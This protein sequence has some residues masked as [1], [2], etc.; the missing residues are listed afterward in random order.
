MF[1]LRKSVLS[2][3]VQ[4]HQGTDYA[5]GIRGLA[6]LAVLAV[7]GGA[8]YPLVE[9][10]ERIGFGREISFNLINLGTAGPAAFFITSGF[11]LSLVWERQRRFGIQKWIIRRY[12]R[13]TPL[14]A[15]VLIYCMLSGLNLSLNDAL[16]RLFYLDAF[17]EKI[18]LRD[19]IGVLWTISIE[20]WLSLFVPFFVHLFRSGK[21]SELVL[22]SAFICSS[23][24]PTALS[25]LGVDDL[26]AGKSILSGVF[27]FVLGSYLSSL[28]KSE[29][30]AKVFQLIKVFA[31]GFLLMYLWGGYM[32]AWWVSILLT[33]SYIGFKKSQ[34][35]DP[36]S[37][38][39]VL[40]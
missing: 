40:L 6:A 7:H 13:L 31:V 20:F 21:R 25:R 10:S 22:L 1:N 32:G 37:L 36:T 17:N 9:I 5:T 2:S 33:T 18:F 38:N 30:S 12:L 26:M 34:I 4:H 3:L 39:P 8:A 35:T 14:Y 23:M 11:V 15:I 16:Y 24:G 28:E 19:P 29:D 27:C